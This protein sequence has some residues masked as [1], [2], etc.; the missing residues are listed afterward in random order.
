[1]PPPTYDRTT[2]IRTY[3]YYV[4]ATQQTE[5]NDAAHQ[6]IKTKSYT[7]KKQ[8]RTS[9]GEQRKP[10]ETKT[11]KRTKPDTCWGTPTSGEPAEPRSS[12]LRTPSPRGQEWCEEQAKRKR[13]N[14]RGLR[15]PNTREKRRNTRNM[16]NRMRRRDR[17]ITRRTTNKRGWRALA[18]HA[19]TLL[20]RTRKKRPLKARR[21]EQPRKRTTPTL[22]RKTPTS[23]R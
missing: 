2:L 7:N 4:G 11:H 6:H 1:M 10:T 21:E 15:N 9:K 8:E 22:T 14:K 5:Q 16:N 23:E 19:I 17:R 3:H 13:N 18:R 20:H 12:D